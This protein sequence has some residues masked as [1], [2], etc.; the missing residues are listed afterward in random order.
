VT[1]LAKKEADEI[2]KAF[3]KGKSHTLDVH[4]KH[5]PDRVS[6]EIIKSVK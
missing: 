1:K 5:Y 3:I 2:P 4:Y 6:R